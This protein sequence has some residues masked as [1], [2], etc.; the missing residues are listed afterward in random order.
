MLLRAQFRALV[1][2]Q[3]VLA[4]TAAGDSVFENRALPTEVSKLPIIT[5]S[6]PVETKESWGRG[7]P[8]FTTTVHLRVDARVSGAT[9]V[10]AGEAVEALL[11]QIELAIL[12]NSAVV[13]LCQQFAAV[14]TRTSIHVEGGMPI[15]TG[16]IVFQAEMVQYYDPAMPDDLTEIDVLQVLPD[17]TD[18]PFVKLDT[19]QSTTR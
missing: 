10:V 2:R 18:R 11:E 6:T 1:A 8:K 15:A 16:T 9:D 12:A 3:L 5:L 14:E 19:L 4:R 13:N 17:G 7:A